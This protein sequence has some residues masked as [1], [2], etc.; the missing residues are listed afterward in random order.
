MAEIR[1]EVTGVLDMSKQLSLVGLLVD[2][3]G[4][5]APQ[6]QETITHYGTEIIG[7]FGVPSPSKEMGLITL[8][9]E[10]ESSQVEELT[11][12][13]TSIEG[14]EVQVASF[15]NTGEEK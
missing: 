10:T 8:V 4:E 6:V 13:L 5:I 14:V 9:M 1:R 11:S 3:R 7:R 2:G 15:K 12:R